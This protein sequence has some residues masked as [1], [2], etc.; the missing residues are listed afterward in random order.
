MQ[1]WFFLKDR[2]KVAVEEAYRRVTVPWGCGF[3]FGFRILN[4]VATAR[5]STH[6]CNRRNSVNA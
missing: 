3:G 6:F 1:S 4:F 2:V 5:Q